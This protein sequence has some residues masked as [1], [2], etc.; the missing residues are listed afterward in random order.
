MGTY[1]VLQKMNRLYLIR[2][3][4]D[5]SESEQRVVHFNQILPFRQT[6]FVKLILEN[7]Y[8]ILE[9]SKEGAAS[10]G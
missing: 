6:F 4:D 2:P 10:M 9:I 5:V 8:K 7:C 3:T 1:L